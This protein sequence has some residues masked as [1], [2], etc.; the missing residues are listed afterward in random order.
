M[1]TTPIDEMEK[2]ANI[3]LLETRRQAKILIQGEQIKRLQA[4]PL[5]NK[6]QSLT[7]NHRKRNSLNHQLK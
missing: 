2:T 6:L 4:H 3:Q 5:H 7:K 1:K